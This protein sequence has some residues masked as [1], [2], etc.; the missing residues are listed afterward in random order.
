MA[1]TPADIN[2]AT[3]M[4]ISLL[5]ASKSVF[6]A[7]TVDGSNAQYGSTAEITNQL[8]VI[9]GEIC[10]LICNTLGHPYQTPFVVTGTPQSSGTPLPSRIGMVLQVLCLAG[11]GNVNFASTD[12]NQPNSTISIA[13]QSNNLVTGSRVQFTTG[14]ALPTGLAISTNYYVDA[15]LGGNLYRFATTR[16]NAFNGVFVTFS[17]VGSGTSTVVMQYEVGSQAL[18]KDE[19][20]A[21]IHYPTVYATQTPYLTE[22]WFI[23]GDI[24]YTPAI[25]CEVVYTDYAQTSA[26]Q[27]PQSYTNAIVGGAIARILK[28]GGDDVMAAYYDKIYGQM[29]Q[30][31]GAGAMTV[32]QISSYVLAQSAS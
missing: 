26:L 9:D 2:V 5:Q 10:T 29:Y 12:V 8:L 4:V 14:G 28:D 18:S 23:E 11:T 21:A 19:I 30:Q 32:P 31:I 25:S 3:E 20:V 24:I 16:M 13:N 27:S 22:F 7:S 1:V 6:P 17:A 15:S